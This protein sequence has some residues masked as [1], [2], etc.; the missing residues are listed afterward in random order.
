MI[1]IRKRVLGL[2]TGLLVIG[3]V[4]L[5][6]FNLSDTQQEIDEIYDAQLAE[7]ARLLEGLMRMPLAQEER[8]DLYTAFNLALSQAA[9]KIDG[10]PYESKMAFQVWSLGGESLVHTPSAPTLAAPPTEPGFATVISPKQHKWRAFVLNDEAHGIRIWVGEREDVRADLIQRIL[11]H[12]LWPNLLGSLLLAAIVWFAIGWGLKPLADL[13]DTLR[14]R[15]PASL[16][17]LQQNPLVSELE[18]MQTALNQLLGRISSV[19]E[20]ERRLIADAAHEMRTPLA[21]L[22]V[23]AQNLLEAGTEQER[24]DSLAF[25]INGVDRTSRL[26]NQLLT[27]ARLEPGAQPPPE[28][29]IDLTQIVRETLAGLTPWLLA[30]GLEITLETSELP[31]TVQ[32]SAIAIDIALNNLVTNAANFSPAGGL[33]QVRLTRLDD[34]VLLS[35]ED[36]GPGID[37]TEIERVFER[38]YGRDTSQG[39]GLGL[40]IVQAVAVLAGGR[41]TLA[42]RPVGGL[43]A[44]LEFPMKTA[45]AC[46]A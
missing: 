31:A 27:M 29:P 19:M 14:A 4:V 22:R 26:V 8:K 30:K 3:L 37:A 11:R 18:P 2:I 13:A 23:H 12:T 24:R 36:Q 21:V 45:P 39:A 20:R 40:A 9:P 10:H 42:N 1:S 33:I 41:V 38:F 15:A 7:S 44:V 17:P 28:Q 46:P 43:A 25:L 34:T 6:L 32:V 35:V 5:S 16:E